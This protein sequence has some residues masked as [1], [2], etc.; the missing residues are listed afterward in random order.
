METHAPRFP[1]NEISRDTCRILAVVL[2]YRT[3]ELSLQA[4]I[5]AHED[6]DS[7][8]DH[9]VIVDNDSPDD[10][11]EKI[12][13]GLSE[14]G[15]SRIELVR[16]GENGGF[17]AGNNVGIRAREAQAYL[18][19]NSD[20]MVR[21]GATRALV[22]TLFSEKTIGICSP[23]LE[24]EDGEPQ[25]SCFRFHSPISEFLKG[26]RTSVLSRFLSRWDVP[27]GVKHEVVDVE[28]TSFAC[29]LMRREVFSAVGL[30]D[31]DFF[32]YYEDA[33]FCRMTRDAGFRIVHNPAAHVVHLR[34]KSSPV[35]EA[36]RL[37]KRRPRYYY[38]ARNRYFRKA[39][40]PLGATL[41]NTLWTM[42]RLVALPRELVGQK[43]PHTVQDEL[44]DNWRGAL[45]SR[46]SE[47]P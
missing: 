8:L 2:N 20:T 11:V 46:G 28:W 25:T 27:V 34:G 33:D 6:L 3:P 30:L 45:G 42:G 24:Y 17:A 5:S 12:Q 10:S 23:R 4:A 14:G 26:A 39:Y 36:S 9:V 37:K 47:K 38:A 7:D 21:P 13:K 43:E 18:L 16:S 41:A 29:V 15:F 40:G 31:E 44:F 22:E 1:H 35:K 19:L 32:M